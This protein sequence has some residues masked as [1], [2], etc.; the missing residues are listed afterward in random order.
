MNKSDL[1][2]QENRKIMDSVA[3]EKAAVAHEK[4]YADWQKKVNEQEE[5]RLAQWRMEIAAIEREQEK[6]IR[7][8][9]DHEL[10]NRKIELCKRIAKEWYSSVLLIL[11]T[12][13]MTIFFIVIHWELFIAGVELFFTRLVAFFDG[14]WSVAWPAVFDFW[15]AQFQTGTGALISTIITAFLCAGAVFGLI[16]LFIK[17]KGRVDD[18]YEDG[19]KRKAEITVLI[20]FSTMV[21]SLIVCSRTTIEM[22]W[23]MLWILLVFGV[24]FIYQT[25]RI[26][27]IRK[28]PYKKYK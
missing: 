19:D 28:H 9:V 15:F 27:W 22:S 1:E 11:Y 14:I 5:H 24:S 10:D 8:K 21:F 13:I 12:V 26:L 17:W 2:L 18:T 23:M 20:T 3:K 16:V 7:K 4:Y 6:V 25:C